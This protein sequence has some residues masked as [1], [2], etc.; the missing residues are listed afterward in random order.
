MYIC[1]RNKIILTALQ[2]IGLLPK[3]NKKT[4][5]LAAATSCGKAENK[6]S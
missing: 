4:M 2:I 3:S 6:K 5:E 1:K